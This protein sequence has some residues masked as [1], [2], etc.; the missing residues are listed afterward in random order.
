M[1]QTLRR[2][3]LSVVLPLS[4]A[5]AGPVSR[6]QLNQ[7]AQSLIRNVAIPNGTALNKVSLTSVD[8]VESIL[9]GDGSAAL[10]QIVHLRPAGFIVVASDDRIGPVIAY[11]LQEPWNSDTSDANTLLQFVKKDLVDRLAKFQRTTTQESQRTRSL[12][13]NGYGG[14]SEYSTGEF[15]QWPSPG[16]TTSEGWI[17]TEWHQNPPFNMFCP[18]D[19]VTHRRSLVGCVATAFAQLV[20]YHQSLGALSFDST[21]VYSTGRI[22]VDGDSTKLKFPSLRQLNEY[23]VRIKEAYRTGMPL[24]DTLQ[25]ALSF[26]CG[27]LVQMDYSWS[28]SAATDSRIVTALQSKL[29][30]PRPLHSGLPQQSYASMI[31][32]CMTGFP[33]LLGI[34]GSD[35]HIVIVDGFNTEGFF[36][37]NFGWGA[38]NPSTVWYSLPNGIPEWCEYSVI[39]DITPV[40]AQ[41][42][43]LVSDLTHVYFGCT[44]L[45]V[46]SLPRR[47]TITNRTSQS[48]SLLGVKVTGGFQIGTDSLAFGDAIMPTLVPANSEFS[49][50][51]RCMPDTTGRID[52]AVLVLA[53]S[54]SCAVTLTGAGGD[55]EGTLITSR[56]ATGVWDKQHSPYYIFQH[57]T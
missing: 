54:H 9:Q 50:F 33:S 1:S 16:T 8:R 36:H 43:E 55:R 37:L 4:I 46:P 17:E 47:I 23:V 22:A 44:P 13:E 20:N 27:V 49:F 24:S 19:P 25:A 40:E 11:S 5:Q 3:V 15:L 10:A 29:K 26:A 18:L 48:I 39:S 52:G 45:N 30:W 57:V 38:S 14:A 28:G 41:R 2:L 32:N 56:N 31:K 35:G 6:Y 34:Y 12:W 7:I 21:D 53:G 51:V 42:G